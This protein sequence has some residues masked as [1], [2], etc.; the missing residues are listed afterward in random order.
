MA[1]STPAELVLI[2]G[3][4][5]FVATDIAL[6]FLEAGYRVRGTVRSQ[7]KAD[8]W[9]RLPAFAPF[10]A[11]GQVEVVFVSDIVRPGAFDDALAGVDYF[12][13]T[14]AQLPDWRPGAQQDMER[15]ILRPNIDGTVNA[16]K[17]ASK[18]RNVKKV[19]ILGSIAAAV[20]LSVPKHEKIVDE[21]SWNPTDYEYGKNAPHPLF[22]YATSKKLAEEAAWKYVTDSKP[23]YALITTLPCYVFG[24]SN[25]LDP[26]GLNNSSQQWIAGTLF[27]SD[28]NFK[29]AAGGPA[30]VDLRDVARAHVL[31]VQ[32]AEADGKR[33]ILGKTDPVVRFPSDFVPLFAREFPERA[34]KLPK[35]PDDLENVPQYDVDPSATEAALGFTFRGPRE[36]VLETA[37]WLIDSGADKAWELVTARY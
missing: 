26:Y 21:S 31:A 15:D 18:F 20:D 6:A 4:N 34:H 24:P 8:I 9:L 25:G 35:V 36:V 3:L 33:L 11:R 30:Y 22:S 23:H 19:V 7:A 32:R 1:T 13:H 2:S 16:L 27:R 17:S 12:L 10:I 28:W 37:C 14:I 29:T 5:G